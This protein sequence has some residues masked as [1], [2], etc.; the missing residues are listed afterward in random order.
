VI[1]LSRLLAAFGFG[2]M[3]QAGAAQDLRVGLATGPTSFDPHYHAHAPSYTLQR[4]VFE[5]LITRA[6]D[7]GLQPTLAQSWAPLPGGAMAGHFIWTRRR[8]SRMARR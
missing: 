4:H 2:L 8:D 1:A 6:A 7:M 5:P 3:A